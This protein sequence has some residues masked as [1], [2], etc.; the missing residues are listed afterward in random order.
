MTASQEES[1]RVRDGCSKV[2]YPSRQSALKAL[3]EVGRKRD[4]RSS[5][6]PYHCDDCKA[7]HLGH[8]NQHAKTVEILRESAAK[9]LKP[10]P[11]PVGGRR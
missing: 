5:M 9:R 8:R 4:R 10:K 2:G 7:W 3:A 6:Q 1:T 11:H